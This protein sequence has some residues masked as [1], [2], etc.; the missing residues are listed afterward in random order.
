[1]KQCDWEQITD[2]QSLNEF[3]KF[4]AWMDEQTKAGIAKEVPVE[5]HYSGASTFREKWFCHAASGKIWRL[6]WPDAPF[7]GTFEPV[8]TR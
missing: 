3:K 1:M 5:N 7:T 4:V 6:V 2:F 8:S